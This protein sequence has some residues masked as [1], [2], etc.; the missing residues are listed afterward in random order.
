MYV[1]AVPL[2]Q[3]LYLPGIAK[4][5]S[6]GYLYYVSSWL[7]FSYILLDITNELSIIGGVVLVSR[8]E[9]QTYLIATIAM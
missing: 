8:E 1:W 2:L 4:H 7:F 6:M 3:S 9:L 5:K